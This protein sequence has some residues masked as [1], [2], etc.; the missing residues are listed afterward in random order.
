[1]YCAG[2]AVQYRLWFVCLRD[3]NV[4]APFAETP[5]AGT[6]SADLGGPAIS[7]L[8]FIVSA[9]LRRVWRQED[10]MSSVNG[11]VSNS[12]DVNVRSDDR[13]GLS[14]ALVLPYGM[15]GVLPRTLPAHADALPCHFCPGVLR[16]GG[17]RRTRTF[18]MPLRTLPGAARS[19]PAAPAPPPACRRHL[20][21]ATSFCLYSPPFNISGR[22]LFFCHYSPYREERGQ[23][24]ITWLLERDG[25]ATWRGI[26][27]VVSHMFASSRRCA[28]MW[29]GCAAPPRTIDPRV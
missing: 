5:V 11:I 15:E 22:N 29:A 4:L 20:P 10:S 7:C 9:R 21:A 18:R 27:S 8:H 28:L 12:S 2:F 6:F 24:I 25:P 17:W 1:L 16:P 23:P 14:G 19:R 26:C 3:D 13:R